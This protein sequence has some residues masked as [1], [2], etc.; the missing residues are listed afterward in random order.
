VGLCKCPAGDHSQHDSIVSELCQSRTGSYRYLHTV[1]KHS[2]KTGA[3]LTTFYHNSNFDCW[4]F[5]PQRALD[6]MWTSSTHTEIRS[7]RPARETCAGLQGGIGLCAG[8]CCCAPAIGRPPQPGTWWR[9]PA[10]TQCI[11][12][13]AGMAPPPA[14]VQ[15]LV[16]AAAGSQASNCGLQVDSR[17][18]SLLRSRLPLPGS[19]ANISAM[20]VLVL[21]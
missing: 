14:S 8:F 6:Q 3:P 9:S 12:S 7:G 20:T 5:T 19:P 10:S 16:H 21:T 1:S 11:T 15:L 2:C 4:I 18:T 13:R 17:M